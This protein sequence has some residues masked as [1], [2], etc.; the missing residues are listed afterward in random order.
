MS[1]FT[2]L[3][4]GELDKLASETDKIGDWARSYILKEKTR[5]QQRIVTPEL[6]VLF[7]EIAMRD[8]NSAPEFID[9]VKRALT[10]LNVVKEGMTVLTTAAAEGKP[11][12]C[13]A[14]LQVGASPDVE[15]TSGSPIHYVTSPRTKPRNEV[16]HLLW[17][18]VLG[19]LLARGQNIDAQDIY[20]CTALMRNCQRTN[21][22][23][24]LTKFL[25]QNGADPHISD[26][27][28]LMPMSCLTVKKS[29]IEFGDA[30]AYMLLLEYGTNPM[31]CGQQLADFD[32]VLGSVKAFLDREP[33][34]A[35][36]S[37]LFNQRAW[38]AFTI[39][40]RSTLLFLHVSNR[41]ARAIP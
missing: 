16:Q 24:G 23:L 17:V 8:D 3:T 28:K 13:Y 33:N 12:M 10:S 31:L 18:R 35:R 37:N 32:T 27:S 11:K 9:L 15:G 36:I 30:E 40:S 38:N 39:G 6:A 5:T 2:E 22:A 20:L 7:Q 26:L 14:L 41:E 21:P 29:N 34:N 4:Q 1:L 19:M 25:L